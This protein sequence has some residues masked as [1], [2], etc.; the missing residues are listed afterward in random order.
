MA[1]GLPSNRS[2]SSTRT[3]RGGSCLKDIYIRPFSS[4]ELAC[5]VRQ[6]SPC[7]RALCESGVLFHMSHLK[8]HFTLHS[9]QSSHFTVHTS[10]CTLHTAP[11]AVNTSLHTVLLRLHTSHFT[12]HTALF[13]PFL[14]ALFTLQTSHF[15]LRSSRPTLHTALFTPHTSSRLSSSHL[16]PAQTCYVLLGYFHVIWAQLKLAHALDLLST[17]ARLS[18]THVDSSTCQKA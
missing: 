2:T 10:H 5:A 16:I 6:P 4:I 18:V 3:R 1:L 9:W 8:L 12:L 15:T 17:S 7:V 13:T 14:T 11:F